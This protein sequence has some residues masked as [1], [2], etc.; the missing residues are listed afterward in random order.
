L[1]NTA[2]AGGGTTGAGGDTTGAEVARDRDLLVLLRTP[3]IYATI[4]FTASSLTM[5]DPSISAIIPTV[6]FTPIFM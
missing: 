2:S 1:P 5:I 4:R 6:K 3:S